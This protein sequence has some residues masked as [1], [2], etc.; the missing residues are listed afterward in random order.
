LRSDPNH[1]VTWMPKR[2]DLAV[3]FVWGCT[4]S[5]CYHESYYEVI[6]RRKLDAADLDAL[7]SIGVLGMGQ[8]YRVIQG[9]EEII[10]SVPPVT[11]DKRNGKA[12]PDVP[13]VNWCGDPITNYTDLKYYRYTIRRICD[14]GD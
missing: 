12:L 14:S 6:S 11:I 2:P 13:P 3:S 10:D 8:E 1:D 5:N 7:D 4:P 9:A